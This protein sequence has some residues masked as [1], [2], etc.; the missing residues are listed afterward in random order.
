MEFG[1][2]FMPK[3]GKSLYENP[4]G[5][6]TGEKTL[7]DAIE[8]YKYIL[9]LTSLGSVLYYCGKKTHI[10]FFVSCF[11]NVDEIYNSAMVVSIDSNKVSIS[12][13]KRWYGSTV[14]E[15]RHAIYEIIG[16]NQL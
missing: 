12:Y 1:N 14:I 11:A 3:N 7:K 8:N 13:N 4:D 6:T 15:N 2:E 9:V 16:F 10:E 5:F